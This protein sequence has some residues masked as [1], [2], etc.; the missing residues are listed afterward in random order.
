MP[1]VNVISPTWF[2]LG[3]IDGTV[4]NLASWTMLNG[5]KQEVTKSGRFFP[6]I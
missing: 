4:H 6:I 3:N 2:S 1:G 5:Q